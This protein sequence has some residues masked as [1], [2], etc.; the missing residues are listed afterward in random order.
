MA[1]PD[2]SLVLTPRDLAS[3]SFA[4]TALAVLGQPIGHS[5][6]PALHHAALHAMA[7]ADGRFASWR[8]FRFEVAPAELPAA[9]RAL[10]RCGFHG[11]NLTVPHKVLA[12]AEVAEIDPAARDAGAV[13]TLL[14]TASGWRGYNTDGQGLAAG[15]RDDLG[16]ELAGRPVL[17]LGAGGAARGAAVECLRRGC[18]GLWIAN[19]TPANLARLVEALDPLRGPIP[20]RGFPPEAPPAD[21]PAG[22]LVINATSAGLRAAD[23]P[24]IDLGRL[25]RPAAVL[26]M[27]YNPPATPLLRAAAALRLPRTNGLSMLVHQGAKALEIWTGAEVPVDVMRAAARTAAI[28]SPAT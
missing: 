9:L 13:N 21:L 28:P 11:L 3:W 5:I 12:L 8:Y 15:V 27:I 1:P 7:R 4:G 23:R 20:V 17:L 24:P 14:R 19:R 25:P 16:L 2:P 22:L 26:D 18:A 6:S 10:H